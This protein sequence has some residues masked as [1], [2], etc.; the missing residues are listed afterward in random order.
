M[1]SITLWQQANNNKDHLTRSLCVTLRPN[2]H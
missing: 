2:N 1:Q